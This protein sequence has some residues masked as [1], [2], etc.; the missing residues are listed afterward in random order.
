M[1]WRVRSVALDVSRHKRRILFLVGHARLVASKYTAIAAAA[2]ACFLLAAAAAAVPLLRTWLVCMIGMRDHRG[3][4]RTPKEG[5]TR[6]IGHRSGASEGGMSSH[7]IT[8]CL[9]CA[10]RCY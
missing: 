5:L 1:I 3:V 7:M 4:L 6:A 2:A 8:A 9:A 10:S